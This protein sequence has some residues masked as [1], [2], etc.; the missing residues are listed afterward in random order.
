MLD[1]TDVKERA[2]GR[3]ND[4]LP[5]VLGWS[6]TMLNGKQQPCPFCAGK[7]RWRYDN[8]QQRGSWICNHCGAGDGFSAIMKAKGC[9]FRTAKGYVEDHIG[10]AQITIPKAT[11]SDDDK[12]A[13]LAALWGRAQPLDGTDIFS[14]YLINRGINLPRWPIYLRWL[15]DMP[16][17]DDQKKRTLHPCGLAKYVAPDSKSA[18]LHRTYLA[19]PGCKAS[20]PKPKMMSEG[21]VPHGG[22]V[23]LFPAGKVL[24]VGEGLE[25]SLKAGIIHKVPVWATTSAGALIKFIPPAGIEHL[26][27]FADV[28]R[29]FTGQVSAYS[30]AYRLQNEQAA[31]AKAGKPFFTIEVR[32]PDRNGVAHW[33]DTGED[34]DWADTFGGTT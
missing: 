10:Q 22:A 23:R 1:R 32:A 31:L 29:S 16:Y 21:K 19:E 26:I 15:P 34:V 13:Q 11:R 3:W 30:L 27:I 6:S 33:F 8:K 14:R 20:I 7:D 25:S 5:L 28:D 4:L 2:I 17:W 18:I 12:R 9:D 24:G